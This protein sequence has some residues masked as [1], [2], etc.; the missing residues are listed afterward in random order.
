MTRL[1]ESPGHKLRMR[2]ALIFLVGL[3]LLG[4]WYFVF[5]AMVAPSGVAGIGPW[6]L[7]FA[8]IVAGIAGIVRVL[9]GA[10][11]RVVAL[12]IDEETGKAVLWLWSPVIARRIRTQADRITNWRYVTGP[13]P[14]RARTRRILADVPGRRRPV[15]FDL[16]PGEPVPAG[17]R[18]F[19]PDAIAAYETDLGIA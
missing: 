13:G 9:R 1:Y 4:I 11:D 2:I 5:Q 18:R 14:A 8:F 15:V 19:A 12:D 7:S 17:L 3:I 6:M 10:G 16:R